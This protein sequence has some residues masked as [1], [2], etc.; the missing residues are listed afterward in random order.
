MRNLIKLF[1]F[2]ALSTSC[3]TPERLTGPGE[4]RK[5]QSINYSIKNKINRELA[6]EGFFT[7]AAGGN[8]YPTIRLISNYYVT[9]NFSSVT[10]EDAQLHMDRIV[11]KYLTAINSEKDIRIFLDNFPFTTKNL[12]ISIV[13]QDSKGNPLMEPNISRVICQNGTISFISQKNEGKTNAL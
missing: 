11:D 13:Y 4:L 8:S 9:R 2:L 10:E 7:Y 1:L 12:E 5:D 6:Q 3:S